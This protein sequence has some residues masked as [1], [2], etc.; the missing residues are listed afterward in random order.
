[1][2]LCHA[3]QIVG[4]LHPTSAHIAGSQLYHVEWHYMQIPVIA[5]VMINCS[6][7]P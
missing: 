2:S 6:S 4:P 5:D 3:L 7:A 1:M